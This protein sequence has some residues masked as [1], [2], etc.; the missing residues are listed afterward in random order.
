MEGLKRGITGTHTMK[1]V[2][3]S[4]I[5]K[6]RKIT[7]AQFVCYYRPQKEEVNRHHIAV[8]R[9]RVDYPGDV[10]KKTADLTTIKCLLNSVL[11][12]LRARFM[13]GDVNKFYI[14]TP[15]DRPE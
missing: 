10:L 9:D 13:T 12:N 2:H 4:D 3:W 7:Y 5:P 8:G 6:Y 15:L 11:S 14:N 1:M